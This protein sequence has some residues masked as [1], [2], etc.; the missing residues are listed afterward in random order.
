MEGHGADDATSS[1]DPIGI[2]SDTS[3]LSKDTDRVN[4]S[5]KERQQDVSAVDCDLHEKNKELLATDDRLK[6]ALAE[7]VR[8]SNELDGNS[9]LL[10][11]CQVCMEFLRLKICLLY[12]NYIQSIMIF[13][14]IVL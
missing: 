3:S 4:S 9:E 2:R 6:S 8:L 13:Q 7:V 5:S 12:L 11:E 14:F 10:N 1:G